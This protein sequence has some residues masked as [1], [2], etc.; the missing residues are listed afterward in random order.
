MNSDLLAT[1]VRSTTEALALFD[2]RIRRFEKSYRT[3]IAAVLAMQRDSTICTIYN[4]NL[5]GGEAPLARIALTMFND[6]ILRVAFEHRLRVIDLRL[7]CTEPADYTN[8][9][10]PSDRGGEKIAQ[11]IA[12]SLGATDT[13]PRVS[14]VYAALH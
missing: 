14:E 1:P 12:R 5:Q 8:Q 10:E 3:A 7:V 11:A 2:N 4:G 9:I 6:V 13:A